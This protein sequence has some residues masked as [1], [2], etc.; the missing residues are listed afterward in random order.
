MN[1]SIDVRALAARARHASATLKLSSGDQ[2]DAFLAALAAL[3]RRHA[4]DILAANATDR[5][6]AGQSGLSA[7]MLDRLLLDPARIDAMAADVEHVAT[8][9]DPL[10]ERFETRVMPNGLVVHK[11]RVALG[12]LGVIFESRPNVAIDVAALA[13]K[14]GNAAVLR[15]GKEAIHSN[16]ILIGIA[17]EALVA[18]GLPADL[19]QFIDSTERDASLELLQLD[20][21]IDLIIPRGGAGLHAFCR[22]ESRIPVITGGIGIC[23]LYV[24]EHADLARALPVIRNAKVQRPTVCNALDTLLVHRAVATRFVPA[25]I[26]TLGADGVEFRCDDASLPL[27]DAVP[28][29]RVSPANDADFDSEWLALI[30]GVR[31]VDH[32]EMAMRHIEKHSS[33]HSDGILTEDAAL[34]AAFLARI[35]SAAVYW[36]ASTR[37]T[38]GAQLGLGAEVAVSTQRLH[39]RGPMGLIELTSY[40]WVIEGAYHVRP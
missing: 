24:D 40:K 34:A 38:D 7:A 23:H 35:D 27:A 5:V 10:G 15:G 3:L 20:D 32:A 29:A 37:F 28:G 8:L 1:P 30:L 39:A 13:I 11:R 26:E 36:N 31:V 16:R 25:V 9:P 18:V 22:R 14:T 12:V 33:G 6:E 4:P 21:L 19:L 2:R 17:R